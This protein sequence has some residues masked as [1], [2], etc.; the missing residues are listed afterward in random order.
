MKGYGRF[1]SSVED[2]RT[3][4]G[5]VVA[6]EA[7]DVLPFMAG[8]PFTRD[9]MVAM[10]GVGGAGPEGGETTVFGIIEGGS[11]RLGGLTEAEGCILGEDAALGNSCELK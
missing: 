9:A 3:V 11:G 5:V 10:G 8:L 1:P 7:C 6:C 2:G 4:V